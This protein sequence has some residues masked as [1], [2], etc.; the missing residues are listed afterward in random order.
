MKATRFIYLLLFLL[1]PLAASACPCLALEADGKMKASMIFTGEAIAV[2]DIGNQHQRTTFR[3][4]SSE[5]G[6]SSR[7]I[8]VVSWGK[9]DQ[10]SARPQPV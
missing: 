9:R 1:S 2:E 7:E 6:P 8:G 3:V 10:N 4:E 5:K